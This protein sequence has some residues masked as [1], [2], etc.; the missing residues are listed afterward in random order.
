M[1]QRV[2]AELQSHG[3][4]S[5]TQLGL[6]V[7]SLTGDIAEALGLS[8][9]NGVL[10]T[11]VEPG[12]PAERAGLLASDVVLSVDRRAVNSLGALSAEVATFEANRGVQFDLWRDGQPLSVQ[13]LPVL[14][15]DATVR[16]KELAGEASADT[17]FSIS[18]LQLT[19]TTKSLNEVAG[20]N[21]FAGGMIVVAVTPG[22]PGSAR[23]IAIGDIIV[24]IGGR[25]LLSA[26]QF[27]D[28]VT[29]ARNTG[30]RNM[31]I[32]VVHGRNTVWMALPI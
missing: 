4:I 10:V 16:A 6:S 5:R 12:S 29:A 21:A 22:S 20:Q 15:P 1:A 28:A 25:P 24:A 26:Q 23:G 32:T 11:G 3:K 8:S 9:S 14:K 2:I 17:L 13:L 31:L 18:G 19:G 27:S 30:R 7:E